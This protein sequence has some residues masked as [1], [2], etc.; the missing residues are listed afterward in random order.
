MVCRTRAIDDAVRDAVAAGVEQVVILGAGMD[1]RPYRLAELR[2]LPVWEVDL[3]TTQ[4]AKK[5]A[6]VRVLGG[7][8]AHV[9]YVPA[10]LTEEYASDALTGTG[11]DPGRRTLVLCEAVSMYMPAAGEILRYAGSLAPGS[12]FVFTYLPRA[13][14]ED[15]RYAAWRRRL[16]WA[17][18]FEPGELAR[19]LGQC[20]LRVSD[21]L[22]AE[23]H[24]ERLLRPA[25]RRLAVFPG[26]RIVVADKV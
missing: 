6:V 13:V 10:D 25:G 23:E 3:P 4:A 8:P 14:A 26:E 5:A 22:G 2:T 20:G 16:R 19:R 7:L 12:R 24:Q 17:T 1:T 15:P 9:R 11:T 18:A 21:D